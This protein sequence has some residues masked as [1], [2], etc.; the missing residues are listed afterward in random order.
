MEYNILQL[1]ICI[2]VSIGGCYYLC[3][4]QDKKMKIFYILFFVF[5]TLYS[6]IGGTMKGANPIYMY[7]YYGYLAVFVLTSYYLQNKKHQEN[8]ISEENILLRFIDSYGSKFVVLYILVSLAELAFPVNRLGLLLNPPNPDIAERLDFYREGSNNGLFTYLG[9]LLFPFFYFGLYKYHNNTIKIALI[10]ISALYITYCKNSYLGRE[11]ML[12]AFAIIYFSFYY[13]SNP[14]NRKVIATSTL[15]S[16]PLLLIFFL[17][18]S[19][20]RV[21]EE[22]GGNIGLGD[23]FLTLIAQ[24]SNYPL[25]FD[26]YFHKSG[27]LIAEYTEWLIL[28]PFPSFFKMGHGG[29]LFNELFTNVAINRFSWESG[30]SIALPGIVGEAI[31]VFKN[32]FFLHAFILANIV[33]ITMNYVRRYECFL[34]LFFFAAIKIPMGISRS[35]TQGVYSIIGKAL[36]FVLVMFIYKRSSKK[37]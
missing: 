20:L 1:I 13:N 16:V 2:L 19:Y 8:N 5:F 3:K 35:G 32:L 33:H 25:H 12:I 7:Y 9:V 37:A 22:V 21:G 31:F 29:T 28:L 14:S 6:G 23:A 4:N 17:Y 34:Y 10:L 36:V 24:E 15:V 11:S 18:Y 26:S 30:F 27:N